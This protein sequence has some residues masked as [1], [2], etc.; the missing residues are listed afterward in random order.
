MQELLKLMPHQLQAVERARTQKNLALFMEAGV[1]KTATT[2]TILREE[3]NLQHQ[4]VNTLILAPLAVCPNWPREFEKFSRIKQEDILVLT[5]R[6]CTRIE[7]LKRR[8]ETGKPC[9]IVTNYEAVQIKPL[10]E[11]LLKWKPRIAILDES[12]RIKDSQSKRAKLIYPITNSCYRKILLTG[13][14]V[15]NS[16]MDIFGQFK[17]LDPDIF[18]PGFWSFRSRYFVNKNA[19]R[20]VT[21]PDWQPQPHA[22]KEIGNT[23]STHSVQAR[24]DECLALPPLQIIPIP[25]PIT[26]VQL[27]VYEQ[28]RKQFVTELNE[29]VMSVEF[30]MVKTLR[31]QQILSGFMQ[32]DESEDVEWFKEQPKLDALMDILDSIGK[33]KAIIW[34]NFVPTYQKIGRA[35]EEKGY[36]YTYL[37]GEQRTSG[38]KAQAIESFTR[39][40]TQLLIANPA[41]A[42]EGINLQEARYAI[43]YSRGY[44]LL[45]YLQS[46]ARN[47]RSGTE[48]LHKS[49]AHYHLF[50][51]GTLDEVIAKAL[52]E[53]QKVADCVLAW[54]RSQDIIPLDSCSLHVT[55]EPEVN[56]G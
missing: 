21:F 8:I 40:D 46:M 16:L 43:Y 11:L 20:Q 28:L 39:G 27:K 14:P 51:K 1:G 19:G 31:M 18:G 22:A 33:E 32:P 3:Y 24:R 44:N 50:A 2:I 7:T 15:L 29:K 36:L 41:A 56:Y 5:G 42:S 6:G 55:N 45:H 53:K 47:Y 49:C 54:A 23:I 12:H 9:I 30:E 25:V 17:A 4:L 34:T 26:G 13:T 52:I 35:L 10:Y 48:K 38:A 37:T